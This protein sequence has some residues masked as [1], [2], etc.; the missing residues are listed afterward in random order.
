LFRFKK[1]NSD[2]FGGGLKGH[3][4]YFGGADS[5]DSFTLLCFRIHYILQTEKGDNLG[6]TKGKVIPSP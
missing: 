3:L 1:T 2:N 6:E 5:D 4:K